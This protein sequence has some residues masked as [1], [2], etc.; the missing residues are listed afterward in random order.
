MITTTPQVLLDQQ[1][2]QAAESRL[3]VSPCPIRYPPQGGWHVDSSLSCLHHVSFAGCAALW[4]PSPC[5]RLS[6]LRVLWNH[7]T[8]LPPS[9][10]LR[11][12]VP[13]FPASG[14][15]QEPPKFLCASLPA[16]RD[17]RPRQAPSISSARCSLFWLP[18]SV[19]RR[20]L[21]LF[22]TRLNLFRGG[23]ASSYGPHSSLC[24]LTLCCSHFCFRHN[25]N[26]WYGRLTNPGPTGLAPRKRH[27][28]SLGAHDAKKS[29]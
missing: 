3:L 23:A 21:F 15:R 26:T 19:Q 22:V 29:A 20:R 8:P 17:L 10:G 11:F 25:A 14:E 27:Q 1:P 16:C 24:M 2:I 6:R 7:L 5:G 9:V 13:S 28:A 12:V 4:S 18:L